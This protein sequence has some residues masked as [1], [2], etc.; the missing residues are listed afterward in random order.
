MQHTAFRMRGLFRRRLRGIVKDPGML[1]NVS[2]TIFKGPCVLASGDRQY[3]RF[4]EGTAAFGL[5]VSFTPTGDI[6]VKPDGPVAPEDCDPW[7]CPILF[8]PCDRN[9]LRLSGAESQSPERIHQHSSGLETLAP[10]TSAK[11]HSPDS[12]SGSP[13]TP[14]S[15]LSSIL[16]THPK[17]PEASSFFVR[18]RDINNDSSLDKPAYDAKAEPGSDSDCELD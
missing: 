18:A 2:K 13:T 17:S 15:P 11:S 14:A 16:H 4:K 6:L 7:N 12:T 8:D 10:S 1:T 5:E 3:V 9:G